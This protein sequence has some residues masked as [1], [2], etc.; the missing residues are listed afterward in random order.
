M[1]KLLESPD[2]LYHALIEPLSWVLI[3]FLW[4]GALGAVLLAGTLYLLRGHAARVRYA[5]S[6]ATLVGL[7]LLPPLTWWMLPETPVAPENAAAAVQAMPPAPLSALEAASATGAVVSEPVAAGSTSW[8]AQAAEWWVQ[9][10]P[11][12][13]SG[14]MLGVLVG[15]GRVGGGWLYTRRLRQQAAPLADRWRCR[16]HALANQLD[17]PRPVVRQSAR[18]NVP[19]VAGWWRPV[20]LVPV[21][22]LTGM[23]P[24]QVEAVMA[25][26]L[27]HIRRHDV[28]VGWLQAAAETLLFYHPAVWW[29]S[30][31]VRIE[32]EHCCDDVAASVSTSR[33]TYARA[34]A[35]LEERRAPQPALALAASDGALLQRIRRLVDPPSTPIA[36]QRAAGVVAAVFVTGALLITAA[37]A[38]TQT[39]DGAGTA[40]APDDAPAAL[41]PADTSDRA[42]RI[43]AERHITERH[44]APSG[45]SA[46]SI[47]KRLRTLTTGIGTLVDGIDTLMVGVDTLVVGVDTLITGDRRALGLPD[48]PPLPDGYA[49]ERNEAP[50][51]FRFR[52]EFNSD[53]LRFPLPPPKVFLFEGDTL[54]TPF[55]PHP[56]AISGMEPPAFEGFPRSP[57]VPFLYFDNGNLR[58]DTIP[59]HGLFDPDRPPAID[60]EIDSLLSGWR[61]NPEQ[62][63]RW[64]EWAEQW[65][66]RADAQKRQAER[67]E[68]YAERMQQRAD[69]LRRQLMRQQPE[70]LRKQA[71]A[72]RRQA[73]RLEEQAR[74][75]EAQ[76]DTSGT[77][78]R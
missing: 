55:P 26:E 75:M 12:V 25:H 78:E 69:S 70:R 20:V 27:A 67:W 24:A 63:R 10:A 30:R 3:H 1:N 72:L 77:G 32:R 43:I 4:Q 31:Q 28:L 49:F 15:L 11:W 21:G 60:L 64:K 48:T 50:R 40:P 58:R 71:E 53:S 46:D 19:L 51:A 9:A 56:P 37:C 36:H 29:V 22:M 16:I 6:L 47:Q 74:E 45:L 7:V 33:A 61:P 38:T 52:G 13:V 62:Q 66:E 17:V 8:I 2:G 14:W 73:E 18:V 57:D 39:P 23:P 76:R 35:T 65:R 5:V 44:D 42:P 59:L 68:P 54:R 41:A 34:L